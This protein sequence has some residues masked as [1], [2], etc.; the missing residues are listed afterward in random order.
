[1]GDRQTCGT[2]HRLLDR[3]DILKI[4]CSVRR[5]GYPA[6]TSLS[7]A[8][9]DLESKI[10]TLDNR[11]YVHNNL[12]L[13]YRLYLSIL[14]SSVAASPTTEY[15]SGIL[16]IVEYTGSSGEEAPR[17]EDPLCDDPLC[18]DPLCIDPLCVETLCEDPL[19]DDTL[20]V[21]TL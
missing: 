3:D 9:E 8:L 20:C 7:L 4:S 21:E 19:C 12:S 1:M 6:Y 2:Q 10:C 16:P 14:L 18:E 5:A 17:R 13:E 11:L 15:S